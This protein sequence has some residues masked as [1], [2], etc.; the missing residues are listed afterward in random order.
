MKLQNSENCIEVAVVVIKQR[1]MR[2]RAYL[3]ASATR[4]M[5]ETVRLKRTA[6]REAPPAYIGKLRAAS[7][8]LETQSATQFLLGFGPL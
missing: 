2:L 5:S 1:E 6:R 8:L 4:A 7:S 3:L